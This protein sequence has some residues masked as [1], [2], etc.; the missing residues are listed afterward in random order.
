VDNVKHGSLLKGGEH[1][2][3]SEAIRSR[4]IQARKRQFKRYQQALKTNS[5]LSNR[6]IKRYINL[7]DSAEQFLNHAASRLGISPRSYMRTIKVAQ[8]IADLAESDYVNEA[9]I[10]EALQYR[11]QK[12]TP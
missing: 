10:G 12:E 5:N 3:S 1:E 7:S 11:R 8:T 4:V 9:H 2:E 6:D